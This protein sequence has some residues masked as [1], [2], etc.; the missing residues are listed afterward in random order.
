MQSAGKIASAYRIFDAAIAD[1]ARR[2]A[3]VMTTT[4]ASEYDIAREAE[5]AEVI[6]TTYRDNIR[7]LRVAG[8]SLLIGSDEYDGS[9][10][11]EIDTLGRLNSGKPSSLICASSLAVRSRMAGELIGTIYSGNRISTS[12]A[13]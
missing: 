11:D 9:V 2:G 12:G 10:L 6:R 13:C 1:A 5:H 7:R 4:A 3:A 8:I